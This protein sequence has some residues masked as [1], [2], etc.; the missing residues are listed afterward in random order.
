MVIVRSAFWSSAMVALVLA[1]SAGPHDAAEAPPKVALTFD[2]LPAHAALPPGLSRTD[3]ARSIITTL[4]EHHAPPTYGFVNAK[5]LEEGQDNAEV[6]RLWR[7]AGHPLANHTFSH[8]DLNTNAAESFEQDVIANEVSLRESM[9]EEDWH[10]LRFPYLSEGD[11]DEKRQAV[12]AFLKDQ[13]YRIADVTMSFDDYAYNDPYARCLAMNDLGS[14]E[15]MK[16]SYLQRAGEAIS[17]G[18]AAG[19]LVYGRD[20]AHVMLLHI[21]GFETVMLPRLLELLEQRG[22]H[23]V[24]LQEAESDPAYAL[25]PGPSSRSGTLWEQMKTA[26]RSSQ[27]ASADDALARLAGLCR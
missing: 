17:A 23:L 10:W 4:Q 6:L 3:I 16:E 15:W 18:Q 20:I 14:I 5:A 8:M 11:T 13:G 2:D 7:A 21:G 27:T 22:F 1:W 24:T 12:A 19:R 9:G 26:R 25:V